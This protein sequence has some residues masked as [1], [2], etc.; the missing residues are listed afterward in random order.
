M[1]HV[2]ASCHPNWEE[3]FDQQFGAGRG[4]GSSG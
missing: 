2:G 3:I 4:G 1:K